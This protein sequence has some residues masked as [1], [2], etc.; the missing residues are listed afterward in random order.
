MN[1]SSLQL[2]LEQVP[3]VWRIGQREEVLGEDTRAAILQDSVKVW[4]VVQD[5]D[6]SR[7]RIP[8]DGYLKVWQLRRPSLQKVSEHQ[9]LLVDEGQDMN[10][11]MLDIFLY[12]NSTRLIV[13][14]PN[15]QIY[16]FRGAVNALD[17]VNPTH[18]YYLT[19]SFRFGPEIAFA[20]N[21]C[22]T[23][24]KGKDHRT[25]VGGKKV[26]TFTGSVRVGRQ[27]AFIGRTN[28][29]V[30]NKLN[31]LM[32]AAKSSEPR[33]RVGLVGGVESYNFED[34]LDIYRL[35]IGRK[36][37]MKKFKTFHSYNQF[38]TFATN[39]D[40]VELLSK[41]KIVE[42]YGDRVPELI[43]R[44][45]S[46]VVKDIK[47]ADTVLSTVHKAKGLEFDTV[48]LMDDFPDFGEQGL[49]NVPEDEANLIYV[50]ITR[51]KI[52]LVVN[53][54]VKAEILS[55]LADCCHLAYYKGGGDC[56]NCSN[57]LQGRSG[58]EGQ[59]L[60]VRREV[61]TMLVDSKEADKVLCPTCSEVALP[62]LRG[63]L[64]PAKKGLKRKRE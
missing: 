26:D 47:T 7:I 60:V 21:K 14:D 49:K 40:D 64:Q 44:I 59:A 42:K 31:L 62:H 34:Y 52:R 27:V 24:F 38:K 57:E 5:K 20:A 63:T 8:H 3:R 61:P 22:L 18:T 15:Q 35:S 28:M 36:N 13:G 2:D 45:R 10:P 16:L 11:A 58:Q 1:S 55:D 50:A 30:F 9:V 39:V 46:N 4:G 23:A 17:L 51:A 54:L 37:D 29:G 43:S 25:L 12:Q 33:H 41:I 32:F 53:S 19:Q 48:V 6:D 56:G